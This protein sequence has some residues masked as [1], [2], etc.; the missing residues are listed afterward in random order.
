MR[1]AHKHSQYCPRWVSMDPTD[2]EIAAASSAARDGGDRCGAQAKGVLD[3]LLVC[4][5]RAGHVG[6]HVQ[7]RTYFDSVSAARD[8]DNDRLRDALLTHHPIMRSET[9]PL[10]G[11]RCGGV[12]LGQDVIEHVLG[13]L[14]D[15]LLAGPLRQLTAERD[16]AVAAVQRVRAWAAMN[17]DM[18]REYDEA[19]EAVTDS[20]LVFGAR[21]RA[22]DCRAVAE[23]V[24]RALDGER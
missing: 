8:D 23:G 11:C 13:E 3:A 20:A 5:Q 12:K 24:R 10:S 19:A 9:G 16:E 22:E 15:G 18:A 7:G 2:A 6:P 21:E 14:A 17:D 1:A 4:E